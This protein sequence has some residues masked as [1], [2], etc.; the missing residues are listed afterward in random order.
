MLVSACAVGPDF[1]TPEA[2]KVTGYAPQPLPEQTSSAATQGGEAQR[3]VSGM[4]VS[5]Q[6]WKTFQSDKL[7]K[8]I[9]D[10]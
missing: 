7:N 4:K 5:D 2:P 9:A 3:F 8:V 1:K 6:W 10:A